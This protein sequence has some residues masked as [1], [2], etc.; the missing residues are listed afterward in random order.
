MGAEASIMSTT[1]KSRSEDFRKMFKE[2]PK[3]ERLVVDYS[4]A[5]QKDILV[6]GRMYISQNWICFYAKIFNWETNLMIPCKD[7]TAITKEKT[8]RVI[9]NAIQITTDKASYFFTSFG[10]R[11]KTYMMLFRIWQNAL[12]DQP[13]D[14]EGLVPIF[15]VV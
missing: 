8:A 9:P 3:E 10:A 12:L 5:L 7:I 4:C 2:V 13:T 1:Y 15:Q 14:S 11:D 6:Q